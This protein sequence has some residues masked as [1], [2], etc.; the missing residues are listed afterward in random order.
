MWHRWIKFA[1]AMLNG[2]PISEYAVIEYNC[3][4]Y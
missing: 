4:A 2:Q 1:P 3:N